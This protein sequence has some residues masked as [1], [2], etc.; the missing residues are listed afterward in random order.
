MKAHDAAANAKEDA[1]GATVEARD[2]AAATARATA[3]AAAAE[4]ADDGD[5]VDH[6]SGRGG[7]S[8]YCR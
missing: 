8:S 7:A 1:L 5:R 4:S 3:Q 2:G 6:A